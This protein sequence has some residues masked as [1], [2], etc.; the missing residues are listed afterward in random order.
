M[1]GNFLVYSILKISKVFLLGTL[2]VN[3]RNFLGRICVFHRGGGNRFKYRAVDFHRRLNQFGFVYSVFYDPNRTAFLGLVLYFN[4]FFSN[5]I[6]SDNVSLG[7]FI[8]SGDDNQLINSRDFKEQLGSS[9]PLS[10]LRLYSI[11]H[12]VELRP[13][14]GSVLARAAGTSLIV[15]SILSDKVVLKSKSGWLLTVSNKCMCSLGFVSN[16]LYKSIRLGKAGKVRGLGWRPVV[17]GIAM[18]PCDHPH[19]GGEGK[20]SP[21]RQQKTPWGKLTKNVHTKNRKIDRAKRNLF[22]KIR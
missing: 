16:I 22:K 2:F 19:G 12:N 3:G 6:L 10:F 1:S 5:I 21:P 18:N 7:S 9:L 17:R 8:F 14:F 15:V 4:G 20:K 13:F 11:V